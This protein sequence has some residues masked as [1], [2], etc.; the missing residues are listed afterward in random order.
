M[1]QRILTIG[2][3]FTW[4]LMLA[5]GRILWITG[6]HAAKASTGQGTISLSL[7]GE[8]GTIYDHN[9]KP[10]TNQ[11]TVSL[12]A[13]TATPE[14]ATELYRTLGQ[15]AA[16]EALERLQSGKPI[17]TEV[18]DDFSAEGAFVVQHAEQYGD[19]PLAV[20]LIGYLDSQGKGVCGI[21]S[22]YETLLAREGR[23]RIRFA[24]D[25]RGNALL[26]V[27]PTLDSTVASSLGSVTLTLDREIQ[28]AVEYAVTGLLDKGAVIVMDANT[29]DILASVS[30]PDYSPEDVG[31]A[32]SSQDSPL[33]NRALSAYNTGSIFKL[34]VAAAALEAGISPQ[35]SYTCTGAID[36]SGQI[37]HCHKTEGHGTLQMS[38]A[39][40]GSC[41]TYF[42]HLAATVGAERIFAMAEAL[43]LG[44]STNLC[45]GISAS[46]GSL[47]D[48]TEISAIPAA[49]A[50]FSIGQGELLTTPLQIALMTSAIVN[51]GLLTPAR[52]V[53]G[54]TQADGT[55]EKNPS[56]RPVRVMSSETATTLRA[57]MTAVV[58][59]GTG[60]AA[61]PLTGGA[62]GKTATAQTGVL[63]EDGE[64]IT[65][66]WFTGFFPVQNPRY[67]VTILAEGGASGS[68]SA[69]PV[70]AAVANAIA[71]LPE[72]A[73]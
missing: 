53:A 20:H 26:G 21:Q 30:L 54:I 11:K 8:R 70:F 31:A 29:S 7:P 60:G 23:S 56:G 27:N 55:A 65:Q 72:K 2:I 37:F 14:V 71:A 32:L 40:S 6:D 4:M 68:G 25:A 50:N 61:Q 58:E 47:P 10:I 59:T 33:I 49:L 42:I 24:A 46:A 66:A 28:S 9:G 64:Y 36:C 51:D 62:G 41:N 73:E 18:P 5:A 15:N 45:E 12:A 52:L 44:H 43:G 16:Q 67:V 38:E 17:L 13:L 19:S 22:A 69:A 48:Q 3:L 34:C 39:L 63:G 57:M 1:K 35:E